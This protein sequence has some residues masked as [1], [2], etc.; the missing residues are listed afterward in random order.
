MI[1]S[2]KDK[3]DKLVLKNTKI[4]PAV[5]IY[6]RRKVYHCLKNAEKVFAVSSEDQGWYIKELAPT[7]I[8][9]KILTLEEKS[10]IIKSNKVLEN[11][12]GAEG[13]L[14]AV[15]EFNVKFHHET[16]LKEYSFRKMYFLIDSDLI[17]SE[18]HPVKT[19]PHYIKLYELVRGYQSPQWL[20][21]LSLENMGKY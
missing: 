1:S 7:D 6:C 12:P 18:L 21:T 9:T 10:N 2:D 5:E 15:V 16:G 14:E 3:N 11:N 4:I 8:A 20:E 19:D 13:G 17:W